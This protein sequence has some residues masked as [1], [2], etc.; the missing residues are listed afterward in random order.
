MPISSIQEPYPHLPGDPRKVV[1]IG[2][3]NAGLGCAQ[4]LRR[5]EFGGSITMIND[6]NNYPYDKKKV[7]KDFD[8]DNIP[9]LNEINQG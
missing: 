9:D 5:M 6:N 3:G 1:I 2:G 4:A 8:L 7:Q